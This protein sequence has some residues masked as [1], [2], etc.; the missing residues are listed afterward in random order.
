MAS[1][2]A[3]CATT[4]EGAFPDRAGEKWA[5][6]ADLGHGARSDAIHPLPDFFHSL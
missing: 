3:P 6:R 5:L 4:A 1:L 2:R